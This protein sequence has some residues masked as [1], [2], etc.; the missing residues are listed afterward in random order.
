MS[1]RPAE[2]RSQQERISELSA[3]STN[4][5]IATGRIR[6]AQIRRGTHGTINRLPVNRG[7]SDEYYRSHAKRA[8]LAKD[9]KRGAKMGIEERRAVLDEA[10]RDG[11]I[12]SFS[13]DS[14]KC[15]CGHVI[16]L[17]TGERVKI[18]LNKNG[19]SKPPPKPRKYDLGKFRTH[20]KRC[21]RKTG[22]A[23]GTRSGKKE[24]IV[25]L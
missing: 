5:T 17:D 20:M 6:K 9:T 11:D 19:T 18:Q 1:R 4:Q 15:A 13:T 7:S 16:S 10:K 21:P 2:A 14:F 22:L 12:S 8:K 3:K 23:A 25:W 24:V